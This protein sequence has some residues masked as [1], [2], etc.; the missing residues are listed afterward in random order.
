M[1]TSTF[2]IHLKPRTECTNSVCN[3]PNKPPTKQIADAIEAARQF[4]RY[5][6]EPAFADAEE[7]KAQ[8]ATAGNV[9]AIEAIISR[10]H[11]E[12]ERLIINPGSEQPFGPEWVA[13]AREEN[14]RGFGRKS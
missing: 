3:P 12:M 14:E 6:T 13:R 4:I 1:E 10:L 5:Y 2:C 9:S 7:R 11:T 8:E